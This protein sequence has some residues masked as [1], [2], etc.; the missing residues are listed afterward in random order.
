VFPAFLLVVFIGTLGAGVVA[1]AELTHTNPVSS[2]FIEQS[3]PTLAWHETPRGLGSESVTIALTAQDSGAGLDEVVVRISQNNQPR[4]LVRR[5]FGA[6]AIHNETIEVTINPKEL[7]LREG[8]AELQVSAFDKSL[9]NNGSR[10]STIVDVNF[11]KPQIAALTPQQNGVLGGTELV[12]YR[13]TGKTPE[14]HGVLS[15]GTL[16]PG[17]PAVGWDERFKGKTGLYVAFYPMPHSFDVDADSMQLVARDS[18][19]N[20]ASGSFNYRVKQRRWSSFRRVISNEAVAPLRER[21][22]SY[23]HREQ[24]SVKLGGD[25]ATEMKSLLK[26]VAFSDEGFIDVAL[27]QPEPSRLWRDAFLPPVPSTPSN[28]VGDL[29]SVYLENQEIARGPAAGVRFPVSKRSAIVAANTG[30]IVF[31][32]ELGL[33][34]NTIVLDHG[35]GLSTVYG[36]LS[37]VRVQRGAVVQRGQEIGSTGSSGFAQ[38]EEVYFEARMHGVPVS[39]NEWWDQTWVTDHIDNKVGFVLRDAR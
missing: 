16:Y 8:N 33:L 35:M 14:S 15:Q 3:P 36:H 37:D 21:L 4:E 2:Q 27:S 11:A 7:E 32:G 17:S 19:G 38:G 26:A 24:L 18:I 5:S 1:F 20:S 31:I 6:S 29:R 9:W 10:I 28:S 13:I 34:G 30:K 39:P 25:S 12:F 23:S 22:V